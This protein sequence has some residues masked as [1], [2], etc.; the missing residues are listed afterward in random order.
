MTG[1]ASCRRTSGMVPFARLLAA[2]CLA[3]YIGL[4]TSVIAQSVSPKQLLLLATT[5]SRDSGV[6]RVLTDAF[7]KKSGLVVK[8][9]T[10]GSSDILKRGSRGEGD[11]VL[12]HSPEVEKAWMAEGNGTSRRLV[13]YDHFVIIGP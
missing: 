3:A 7:A 12:A 4:A 11:V 1:D 13:M 2:V 5:T 8:T 6:L 10:G 9:I